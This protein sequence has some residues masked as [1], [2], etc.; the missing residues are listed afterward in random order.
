M[1]W[2]I[3]VLAFM[4]LVPISAFFLGSS[5]ELEEQLTTR[6]T[7]TD[8]DGI[9]DSADACPDGETGWTSGSGNDADGDGCLDS[10]EDSYVTACDSGEWPDSGTC[11]DADAG[12]YV[13]LGG[14]PGQTPCAP[15]T[16]QPDSG[17]TSCLQADPGHYVEN[18]SWTELVH[19][20]FGMT[21]A[22]GAHHT[23]AILDDGSV[24]CWGENG[25]G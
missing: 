21:I 20:G 1:K 25:N 9:E 18:N 19:N 2:V 22:A 24:S 11:V 12:H 13:P 7:D 23:C 8:G 6:P 10:S 16:Y 14:A 15:G 17:Q 3:A 4:L 5:A